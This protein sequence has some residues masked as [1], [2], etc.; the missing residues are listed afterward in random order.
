[1]LGRMATLL[2]V[3]ETSPP[4]TPLSHYFITCLTPALPRLY[5]AVI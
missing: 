1:V 3:R 2:E 4:R 5:V